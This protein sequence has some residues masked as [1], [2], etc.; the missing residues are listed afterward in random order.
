MDDP[1]PLS[2]AE[3]KSLS[4][5][6]TDPANIPPLRLTSVKEKKIVLLTNNMVKMNE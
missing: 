3:Y 4:A 1:F 5:A 6:V 2:I